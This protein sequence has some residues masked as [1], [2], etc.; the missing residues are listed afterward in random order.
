MVSNLL[1]GYNRVVISVLFMIHRHNSIY[2]YSMYHQ[3]LCSRVGL[4]YHQSGVFNPGINIQPPMTQ[5]SCLEPCD[6]PQRDKQHH[7]YLLPHCITLLIPSTLYQN[8]P[9]HQTQIKSA[10]MPLVVP[11]LTSNSGDNDQTN[12]WMNELVGKKLGDS[13]N[14]TVRYFLLCKTNLRSLLAAREYR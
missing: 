2:R 10:N 8:H 1:H 12:K 4:G 13:S 6:H 11:G 9:S 7:L 3:C 5:C 14:E